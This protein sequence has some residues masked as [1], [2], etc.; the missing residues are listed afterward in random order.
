MKVHHLVRIVKV[1]ILS[2]ILPYVYSQHFF[3]RFG[4]KW[5]IV[6]SFLFKYFT[7]GLIRMYSWQIL[8]IGGDLHEI[9]INYY[10]TR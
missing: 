7:K 9:I 5:N 3:E 8:E 4:D 6:R 10:L 2:V 1:N